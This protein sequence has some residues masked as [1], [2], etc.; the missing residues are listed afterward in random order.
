[1][2]Y[3]EFSPE[4]RRKLF[5]D[6]V[7]EILIKPSNN[8]NFA[9]FLSYIQSD[10]I[11]FIG[12]NEVMQQLNNMFMCG[13]IKCEEAIKSEAAAIEFLKDN[14]VRTNPTRRGTTKMFIDGNTESKSG[15]VIAALSFFVEHVSYRL[16]LC[17]ENESSNKTTA[18]LRREMQAK[19]PQMM[20]KISL[21]SL[22]R[23]GAWQIVNNAK[24]QAGSTHFKATAFLL[25][26]TEVLLKLTSLNMEELGQTIIG[27]TLVPEEWLIIL[28]AITQSG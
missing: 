15:M 24:F 12:I 4:D 26:F 10:R 14:V 20:H 5:F 3:S 11:E 16:R 13:P 8:Y 21:S 23:F 22:S 2:L 18:Q 17:H 9:N 25:L 28:L 27:Q 7:S 6:L 19:N 1:M